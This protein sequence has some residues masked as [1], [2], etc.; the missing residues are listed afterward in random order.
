M[1]F[2]LLLIIESTGFATRLGGAIDV[3]RSELIQISRRLIT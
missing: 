3:V 1:L 2:D